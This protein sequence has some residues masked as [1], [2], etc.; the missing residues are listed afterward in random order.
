MGVLSR[1]IQY[2]YK[3]RIGYEI[4]FYYVLNFFLRLLGVIEYNTSKKCEVVY[5]MC[6]VPN[7][8]LLINTDRMNYFVELPDKKLF[9]KRAKESHAVVES[10]S[11]EDAISHMT[12]K[13]DAKKDE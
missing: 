10:V 5:S 7:D 11:K 12:S 2:I 8:F 9:K 4:F 13:P 6:F 3:I 1:V